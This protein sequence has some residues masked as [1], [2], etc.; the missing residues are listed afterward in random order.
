[1]TSQ[2]RVLVTGVGGDLGQAIV[3]AL[4]LSDRDIICYGC[5]IATPSVGS[6][7]VESFHRVP[8]ADD[9]RY[10]DVLRQL[11]QDLGVQA[12]IPG[13]EPETHR[14]SRSGNPP[15]LSP[16]V[17]AVCQNAEWIST[18][19]DKLVC[20][21]ALADQIDLVPFAD[22]TDEHAVE[23][24]VQRTGFPLVV[25][26]RRSSG[27]KNFGIAHDI[28]SLVAMLAESTLPLVQAYIDDSEGEFS[29]GV[30]VAGEFFQAIAFSRTL[31]P[32]GCSWFAET[33]EDAEVLDY[34]L[35]ITAA[36][37]VRGSVNIQVRKGADGVRLLE[38][39]PRFSSLAA[40]RA[41]CGFKDVEWAL[42]M[43]LGHFA[44]DGPQPIKQMRFYRFL[45][46]LVDFGSGL[47]RIPEW[48]A[49]SVEDS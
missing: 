46:E 22:G 2:L 21:A 1:M 11:C 37:Q 20:M 33:S 40:A 47:G 7:F 41:A 19:G 4:R 14:I 25:K 18:Y 42:D 10:L 39:N 5:D 26:E 17:I 32:G 45:G 30:F 29:V 16:G 8:R 28:D 31:G 48:D 15:K 6:A 34:A 36:S 44:I 9:E 12:I 35:Q 49:Q 38:I 3:K 43:A 27:G 23:D 24:L 13:S